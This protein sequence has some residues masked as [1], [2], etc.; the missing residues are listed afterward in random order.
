MKVNVQSKVFD[1][2]T[3][4]LLI[5]TSVNDEERRALDLDRSLHWYLSRALMATDPREQTTAEDKLQRYKILRKLMET[6]TVIDF[7]AEE[8]T[9]MKS[10]VAKV[11]PPLVVGRSHELLESGGD[12]PQE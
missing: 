11:Y 1:A 6:D 2:A 7:T 10:I 3:R 8:I 4:A 5:S 12:Q 9:Q